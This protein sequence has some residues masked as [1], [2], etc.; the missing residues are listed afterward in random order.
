MKVLGQYNCIGEVAKEGNYAK[1]VAMVVVCIDG[2]EVNDWSLLWWAGHRERKVVADVYGCDR[3]GF[4]VSDEP[5]DRIER[6]IA[7]EFSAEA[8]SKVVEGNLGDCS[9]NLGWDRELLR[10]F[11]DDTG[12]SQWSVG[13]KLY[14]P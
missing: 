9:P 2:Y 1:H 3:R 10:Q 12:R 6:R 5:P 14:T 4:S 8:K 13:L 7:G 11:R